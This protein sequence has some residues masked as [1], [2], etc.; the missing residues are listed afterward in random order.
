MQS[1]E[2]VP[3]PIDQSEAPHRREMSRRGRH[4]P[5]DVPGDVDRHTRFAEICQDGVADG[6]WPR[7]MKERRHRTYSAATGNS[8]FCGF[9]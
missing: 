3:N 1:V 8:W 5:L 9:S 7:R 2:T 4:R 6:L